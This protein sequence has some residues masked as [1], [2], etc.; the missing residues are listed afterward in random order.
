MTAYY[1]FLG[2]ML[3]G[4]LVNLLFAITPA[5]GQNLRDVKVSVNVVNVSLEE[6]LQMI[7]QKT[8]FK[9]IFF[10]EGLPL[11]EKATVIVDEESLYNILEVFAK[12]YGLTFNR[13]NDQIVVK[14]NQG[15]T[16]NLVTAIET[17]TIKGKVTDASTKEALVGAS[18]MLRGT[19]LG[20]YTDKKGNFEINNV[21][22]G[23]YTIAASYVGYSTTTKT[24]TVNAN[25]TVD[26]NLG[27]GQSAINLDEVTVTGTLAERSVRESANP[28]S[29]ILP[30]ELEN[31]N[32]FKLQTII[33]TLPGVLPSA[34]TMQ[35][36][37]NSKVYWPLTVNY[38]IR[39][40]QPAAVGYTSSSV[41]YILDGVELFDQT[42]SFNL[43]PN[44]IEKI[45]VS[46]GPMSSTLY[47]NGAA[48]GIVQ[49]FTKKGRS[50]L[51]VNFRTML[52]SQES[53][54]QASNPF[55]TEYSLGLR[56]G[57]ANSYYNLNFN[58]QRQPVNRW[59]LNSGQDEIDWN[60]GG[61]VGT[62]ISNL[63]MDLSYQYSKGIY[64]NYDY[65]VW[66]TIA[67]EE[68]WAN[69]TRLLNYPDPSKFYNLVYTAE[70]QTAAL[71]LSQPL[72][73]NLYHKLSVGL[74]YK[75]F[76]FYQAT[77]PSGS[78]TYMRYDY[79]MSTRNAKYFINYNPQISEDFK[80]DLTGGFDYNA[81]R[82]D[83]INVSG[84]PNPGG[85][86]STLNTGTSGG[87][88]NY[89][90]NT[91]GLFGEAVLKYNDKLFLTMGYRTE[92]NETY[93][94]NGW[95]SMPRLGLSYVLETGTDFTAK[96]RSSWGKSTQA[97]PPNFKFG[98]QT[99]TIKM[100]P[101]PDLL[102]QTQFGYEV[103]GDFYYT[104]NFSL[105]VT[106]F[107]QTVDNYIYSITLPPSPPYVL[108]IQSQNVAKIYNSG[109]EFSFKTILAP[110]TL[111]INASI[112]S[113]KY[114][115]GNQTTVSASTAY[116]AEGNRCIQVPSGSLYAKLTY[117]IPSFLPW[118]DKGG[119]ISVDYRNSGS[120]VYRDYYNY[121]KT[122]AA[123]GSYPAYNYIEM[124]GY[125]IWGMRF[126]Y[127]VLNNIDV[128][129]DV[130]N[131]LNNQNIVPGYYGPL[132]GRSISFGFN[133]SN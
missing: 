122:Y 103:G 13:I 69:P 59:K 98:G 97:V 56:G 101:N 67:T 34:Q 124:A 75:N 53:K 90:I 63:K 133:V 14:K 82:G 127:S 118:A 109:F 129:C 64:G 12:D 29:V 62:T 46:R 28:I 72:A 111:D 2:L 18:V 6:A 76:P 130:Q 41:K 16:E 40:L 15:Q 86:N 119:S 43:D 85:E 125:S 50:A 35:G 94:D 121:Y 27:L 49:I 92:K 93:G 78:T 55:N 38:N 23:K 57:E 19:T 26:I 58:Y 5:E 42:V 47:G 33:Q 9:F 88:T 116:L 102:P 32:L 99:A 22:P 96:F 80:L 70:T 10:E 107:N 106:Y 68:G 31:R 83:I 48:G 44:D 81:Q 25:Q 36:Y 110:F 7:E 120:E 117:S 11:K 74:S 60:V 113:S 73:D 3:Q 105:G 132:Q 52:V 115:P 128:F 30:V 104:Q 87:Y 84:L 65:P 61:A 89:T 114:G 91:T 45:E 112:V 4:L 123:T 79:Y 20:S 24:I 17:G 95:Y 71:N 21:K 54:V 51:K 8:N 1:S 131:L 77:L 126:N 66:Y 108:V 39:G 37:Q 100:L